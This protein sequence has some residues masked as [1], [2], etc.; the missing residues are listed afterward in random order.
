[1]SDRRAGGACSINEAGNLCQAKNLR[2]PDYL[3]RIRCLGNA[4]VLLQYLDVEQPPCAKALNDLVRAELQFGKQ[5]RLVLAN[6]LRTKTVGAPTEVFAEVLYSL[7][8]GANRGLGEVAAAQLL[9]H[10]L[11]QMGH[12]EPPSL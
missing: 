1:L 6:V 5:H 7:D 12:R 4:P 10:E 2:Q 11:T 8:V 9:N 3:P